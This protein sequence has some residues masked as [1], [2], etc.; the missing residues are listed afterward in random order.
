MSRRRSYNDTSTGAA[1][2][3]IRNF[4]SG[5]ENSEK[6]KILLNIIRNELTARQTEIILLYYF[7]EMSITEISAAQNVTPQAV[8]KV[9]ATARKKIF[10]YMKYTF[11]E[12]L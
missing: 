7:K 10:R 6:S 8:S 5:N 9:M 1:D 12:F 3:Y 4:L 11:K 2:N